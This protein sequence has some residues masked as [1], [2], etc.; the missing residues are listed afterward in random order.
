[1]EQGGD[2]MF[3]RDNAVLLKSEPAPLPNGHGTYK[4]IVVL[5]WLN[6]DMTTTTMFEI[7]RAHV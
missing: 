5:N 7:G 1:M 6:D 3:S 4:N 2:N